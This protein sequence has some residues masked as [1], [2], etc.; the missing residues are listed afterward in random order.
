[1]SPTFIEA[2][3]TSAALLGDADPPLVGAL[4]QAASQ[5]AATAGMM[6]T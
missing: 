5:R 1:L 2:V 3:W 6:P 4:P